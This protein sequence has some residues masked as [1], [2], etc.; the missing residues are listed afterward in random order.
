MI[1][2]IGYIFDFDSVDSVLFHFY[3]YLWSASIVTNRSDSKCVPIPQ[4]RYM[5]MH[6]CGLYSAMDGCEAFAVNNHK[7]IQYST[8]QCL[9]HTRNILLFSYS[10]YVLHSFFLSFVVVHSSVSEAAALRQCM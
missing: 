9:C 2:N 3:S 4:K 1:E 7:N 6:A 10:N 8:L 5:K